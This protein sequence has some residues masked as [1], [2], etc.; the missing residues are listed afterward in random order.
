MAS[1]PLL[2]KG[3]DDANEHVYQNKQ[4]DVIYQ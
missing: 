4:N 3:E 2:G 1:T